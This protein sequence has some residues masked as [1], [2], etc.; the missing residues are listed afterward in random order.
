MSKPFDPFANQFNGGGPRDR[1]DPIYRGDLEPELVARIQQLR[2]C[3]AQSSGNEEIFAG[4]VL[5]LLGV[6]PPQVR[7]A[8]E[9]AENE[10]TE[11]IAEVVAEL[12]K[13]ITDKEPPTDTD[14]VRI[15][16]MIMAV[17]SSTYSE[18]TED[19]DYVTINGIKLGTPDHP[20]Y[21]NKPTDLDYNPALNGGQP[22][23]ISP[24]LS[25]TQK[26][27]YYRL[28]MRIGEELTNFGLGWELESI[29]EE[30][31]KIPKKIDPPPTPTL[32]EGVEVTV[33]DTPDDDELPEV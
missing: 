22:I 5:A 8:V 9:D 23:L 6:I 28:F 32:E 1:E 10:A 15:V 33:D 27:D 2:C 14:L 25:M 29:T 4:A 7:Y 24:K 30:L 16:R 19:W 11:K 12:R 31:G 18:E 26:V 13:T 3:A 20:Y 21:T 17:K